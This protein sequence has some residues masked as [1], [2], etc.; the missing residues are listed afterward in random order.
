MGV[1]ANI[2]V[3]TEI[4]TSCYN[5][6]RMSYQ[7]RSYGPSYTKCQYNIRPFCECTSRKDS[8]IEHDHRTFDNAYYERDEDTINVKIL[9]LN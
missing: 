5:T 6:R 8:F 4:R 1:V 2:L 7:C 9:D 3:W